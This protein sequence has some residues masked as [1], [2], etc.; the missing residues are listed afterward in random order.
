MNP[1]SPSDATHPYMKRQQK[2]IAAAARCFFLIFVRYAY[3]RRTRKFA[4][5]FS[6]YDS[7]DVPSRHMSVS[8]LL[9]E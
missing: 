2:S 1:T 6:P 8:P 9:T 3:L 4:R 5:L 7:S